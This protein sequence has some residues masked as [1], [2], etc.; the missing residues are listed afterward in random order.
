MT[1]YDRMCSLLKDMGCKFTRCDNMIEINDVS[2][3]SFGGIAIDFY[4]NGSFN[5]FVAYE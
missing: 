4:D 2:I 5:G 1:D 3:I